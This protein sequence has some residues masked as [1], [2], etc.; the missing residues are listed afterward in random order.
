[1]KDNNK[2][3]IIDNIDQKLNI[4]YKNMSKEAYYR[5]L[6]ENEEIK[7][8]NDLLNNIS[9]HILPTSY[10]MV[11][12]TSVLEIINIKVFNE[13]CDFMSNTKELVLT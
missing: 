8:Y 3:K 9:L 12:P 4:L 2:M 11:L 6:E 5:F 1:M 10:L 7:A 13:F